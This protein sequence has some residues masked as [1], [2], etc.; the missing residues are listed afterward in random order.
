[1]TAL[2]RSPLGVE[3][4]AATPT[5]ARPSVAV[6]EPTGLTAIASGGPLLAVSWGYQ[7]EQGQ[8]Q[9][10]Y[11]I[12]VGN[13]AGTV[14]Y[15]DT[16]WLLSGAGGATLNLVDLGVPTDTA[17]LSVVVGARHRAGVAASEGW[18]P[19]RVFTVEWG[20]PSVAIVSPQPMAV[21]SGQ[22]ATIAWQFTS[23]RGKTQSAWRARLRGADSNVVYEDTGWRPGADSS[24]VY[25]W[26]LADGTVYELQV[27]ARNSEGVQTSWSTVAVSSQ[28]TLAAP[29]A[30]EPRVGTLYEIGLNGVGYMLAD[31]P[32]DDLQYRRR[33]VSLDPPRLATGETPFSQAVERYAFGT[34]AGWRAGRG[35]RFAD[36]DGADGRAFLDSEGVD[37]FG[38]ADELRLLHDTSQ[39]WGDGS[40]GG[41][42]T[43]RAAVT[44]GSDLAFVTTEAPK[45]LYRKTA[46]DQVASITVAA[47]T[48][49]TSLASDGQAWYAAAGTAGIFKG[50]AS[51]PGAAWSSVQAD[52]VGWGAGRILAGYKTGGSSTPNRFTTIDAVGADEAASTGRVTLPSG[53]TIGGFASGGGFV[54]FS[55]HSGNVGLI[56]AWQAGSTD[57]PFIAMELPFPQRAT[58]IFWYQGQLMVRATTGTDALIYR[59]VLDSGGQLTPFLVARL[60]AGP[61]G[62]SVADGGFAADERLV[63]FAWP[64]GGLDGEWSGVGAV[65]LASG[66]HARWYMADEDGAGG[67]VLMWQGKLAFTVQGH[68]W[69][70]Q[71]DS[72]V[73]EGWLTTSL[74][75]GDSHL[76][77]VWGEVVMECRPLTHGTFVEV[78]VSS[79]KGDSYV[80]LLEL[81]NLGR[82]RASADAARRSASL[83]LKVR[84]GG[85]GGGTPK[86]TMLSARYHA[87]GLADQ[88][89][90]LPIDCGDRVA[91]L[92]G[93]HLPYTAGDG[94]RR[95]RSLEELVQ[96]RVRYQDVDWH[97]T[98]LSSV[99]DLIDVDIRR[100][101]LKDPHR[102]RVVN[103]LIALVTL[104]R[105]LK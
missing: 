57:A 62:E 75:D 9:R 47:A 37:P 6:I 39:V 44:V 81:R 46:P 66:G 14:T 16:G 40:G 52:V 61:A 20:V 65:D 49:I 100:V 72:Y 12:V 92:N 67:P 18:S 54:F 23:T 91:G 11:R 88:L 74:Y 78:E 28:P 68:G 26:P 53:W 64:Y 102:G 101:A 17:D 24:Y 42:F 70:L 97:E 5:L 96:T 51:D 50:L 99:W 45:T 80:P 94:A 59:C 79:N 77:K 13:A 43:V 84:L 63:Y 48:T 55:A 85:D 105:S 41:P 60:E 31:S 25:G 35:Q 104:R 90:V 32:E 3:A 33:T 10:Q 82:Q 19:R 15:A 73:T 89:V 69:Y 38:E 30:E 93:Q 34:S 7:Q 86:V 4:L 83:G 8:P 95:A 71:S 36:R 98:G 2:G 76:Q 87:L 22:T 58:A 29:T 103:R 21:I 27:A 56:Y 1:M